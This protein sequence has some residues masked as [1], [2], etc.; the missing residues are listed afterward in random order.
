VGAISDIAVWTEASGDVDEL[1]YESMVGSS[2]NRR[3]E[4]HDRRT[5]TSL[6]ER[7]RELATQRV[8]RRPSLV[9][10]PQFDTLAT[11]PS[12]E[13]AHGPGSLTMVP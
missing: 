13:L 12:H 9:R 7:Y 8:A 1:R 4:L 6:G 2:V 3:C 10:H 11:Q 5:E